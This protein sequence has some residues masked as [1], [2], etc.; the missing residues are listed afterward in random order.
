[1]AVLD[2][3]WSPGL[4][5]STAFLPL[6]F[7]N[8]CPGI[9]ACGSELSLLEEEK[10][11]R[12]PGSSYT[13]EQGH[14]GFSRPTPIAQPN[15]AVKISPRKTSKRAVQLTRRIMWSQKLLSKVQVRWQFVLEE[16][17]P[18]PLADLEF[19]VLRGHKSH[20]TLEGSTYLLFAC[21]DIH[22]GVPW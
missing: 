16:P 14:H 7:W 19:N 9:F 6:S 15:T 8:N 20:V 13:C 4:R 12:Y 21:C 22:G 17:I 1:M 18:G 2:K 3:F 11:P 5:N 10:L